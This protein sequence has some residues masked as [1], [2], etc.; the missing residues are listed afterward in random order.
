MP[1]EGGP[2]LGAVHLE[3]T[4]NLDA[5]AFKTGS[6]LRAMYEA[7]GITRIKPV[8]HLSGRLSLLPYSPGT[9][10]VGVSPTT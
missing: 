9:A 8:P 5:G 4:N 7:K 10:T 3:W 2:S 6:E 1:P